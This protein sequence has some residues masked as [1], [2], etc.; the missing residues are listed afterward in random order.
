MDKPEPSICLRAY[1]LGSVLKKYAS[2]SLLRFKGTFINV[3]TERGL[4]ILQHKYIGLRSPTEGR[5]RGVRKGPN[6]HDVI[7]E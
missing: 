1:S 4:V 7:Y 3:V 2:H 6:L 5:G